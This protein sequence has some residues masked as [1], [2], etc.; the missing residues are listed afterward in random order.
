MK[1][2]FAALIVVCGIGAALP[3]R[4]GAASID[5]SIDQQ[6]RISEMVAIKEPQPLTH[7]DFQVALG[8]NV[9]ENVALHPLPD[10]AEKLAPQLRGYSYLAVEELVAIVDTNSRNIVTVM[11]RMRGQ[12]TSGAGGK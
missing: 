8:T 12:E 4:A 5:L 10:E 11:Q 7:I 2:V 6:N 1:Q 3:S 9:P